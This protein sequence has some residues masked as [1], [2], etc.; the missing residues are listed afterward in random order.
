MVEISTSVLS[1]NK[2]NAIK[3]LYELEVAKTDYF[4]IDVMDGNFV[5]NNTNNTMLEYC[6]YLNSI[7]NIPLDIHLMVADVEEYIKQY[8]VFEPNII[9]FHIEA[10]KNIEEAK[11]WINLIKENNC[12]VG[13]S[14][15]PN[16]SIEEVYDVLPY[17]H[18][19]LVMTVE[20]G[21]GGQELIPKTI[22]KI[23]MLKQ[24]VNENKLEVDI[25][26]DGGINLE[27]VQK[28]TTAG[29][30]IIVAGVSV[31]SSGNYKETI[32]KLKELSQS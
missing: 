28:L 23:K 8:L 11:K 22:E 3:T 14:I 19:V 25:A 32:Q 20:P 17:I 27:N 16:T 13:V 31:T 15:K 21:K 2:E 18:N 10:A 26:A 30:N 29:C 12:K 4:H 1:I 24:Y 6:E 9:T 7:T 5:E